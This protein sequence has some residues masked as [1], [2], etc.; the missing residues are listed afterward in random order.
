V[1]R[2]SLLRAARFPFPCGVFPFFRA[3]CFPFPR[4]TF[5]YATNQNVQNL[6]KKTEN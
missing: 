1:Q 4:G 5:F 2:V 3:A 6:K